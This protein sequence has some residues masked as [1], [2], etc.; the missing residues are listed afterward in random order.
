[1]AQLQLGGTVTLSD[2]TTLQGPP[3]TSGR[4][5]AILGDTHDPSPIADL[6]S[7][8]DLLIHEATN[9]HLPG[10]YS[11]TKKGDTNESVEARAI[12]RG[13]STPQMAGKFARA[14]RAQRLILNHFSSR[15]AGND[16]KDED[17][18]TIMDAIGALA[19]KEFGRPVVCSRDF[20][21]FDVP[22]SR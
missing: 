17:A 19:E 20:M 4:K 9:A 3:R 21:T 18:K 7:D 1:M 2:G 10:I 16:D 15:Y 5:V 13:H 6:A 14:V 22:I 11:D 8:A 12:S